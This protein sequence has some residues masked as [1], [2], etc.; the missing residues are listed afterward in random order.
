MRHLWILALFLLAGAI[1][2]APASAETPA[3]SRPNIIL[4]MADDLGFETLGT[5]GGESYETPSLDRMAEKGMRF[6]NCYS[7]PLC[8]PS[9]VQIMTG[10]YNFR[11]YI[12]FGMLRPGETTF[13]HL[14]QKAG[15]RVGITGKWQLYGNPG[16]RKLFAPAVG[17]HPS[18][19]GFDEYCLWQVD[20]GPWEA[21]YKDPRIALTGQKPQVFEGEYGPD[22][23]TGFALD[24]IERHRD[25]PFLL[26]YPMCL[27]H[28][29]F[30]PTP[31]HSDYDALD[32]VERLND[33]VHFAAYVAYMD[34]IVG[35]ILQKVEDLGLSEKTLVLFTG[36]NGTD[37]KVE[38]RWRGRTVPGMKGAPVEFG[39]HVPL[40]AQW[41]GRVPAGGRDS[42]LVDFTDFLPTLVEVA[43]AP[44]P[45]GLQLDGQSFL[46]RL[47]GQPGPEREWVFCHY[48][49]RW[50]NWGN[51]RYVHDTEWKLH[52]DGRIY[53]IET[54]PL[55][56]GG[57]S[58]EELP[59]EVQEKIHSFRAVLARLR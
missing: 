27:T 33:P 44:V 6:E 39:T 13:G 30:Q 29:P 54:D 43:G 58:E 36:D 24:F 7:T 11:N 42:G 12:G 55:E 48:A 51:A 28:D 3:A 22:R 16:Q 17:T 8:T 10:Q 4:I 25:E 34:H 41:P 26:Y 31:G 21:R 9:R 15:Y 56:E 19:A 53:H 52:E 47:L 5:Y 38:S 2:P 32:P 35:R 45:D 18:E 20:E 59:A 57:R 14:L 1:G 50:G 49:P 37:T 46:H 40:L 23:Y